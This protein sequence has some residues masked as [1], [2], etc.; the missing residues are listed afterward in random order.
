MSHSFILPRPSLPARSLK[1]FF[2]DHEQ[3]LLN[4]LN[5]V[6]GPIGPSVQ[7]EVF[8]LLSIVLN[9]RAVLQAKRVRL[10][11]ELERTEAIM[12][13]YETVDN[14][15]TNDERLAATLRLRLSSFASGLAPEIEHQHITVSEFQPSISFQL[16]SKAS[17]PFSPLDLR[18]KDASI[19]RR[20]EVLGRIL[21]GSE[22]TL[23][24]ALEDYKL[25][26][27]GQILQVGTD[28]IN[29]IRRCPS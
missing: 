2:S 14:A 27:T 9:K 13:N 10:E 20:L 15:L 29:L 1:I 23:N 28:Q 11:E 4:H 19:V 7:A 16:P 6:A 18:D 25:I 22:D 8:R 17:D 26:E 24:R 3:V 12:Y 5:P 21:D